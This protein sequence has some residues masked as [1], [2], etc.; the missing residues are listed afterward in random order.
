MEEKPLID[1]FPMCMSWFL[2]F[3]AIA[4]ISGMKFSKMFG[5]F[6]FPLAKLGPQKHYAQLQ[7]F[8][9]FRI[10]LE[11]KSNSVDTPS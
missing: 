10:G 2:Y 9:L 6:R 3:D 1:E 11:M 4:V 7:Y 5:L 8:S